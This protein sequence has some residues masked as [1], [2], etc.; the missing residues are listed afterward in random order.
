MPILTYAN[1]QKPGTEKGK[2]TLPWAPSDF[3]HRQIEHSHK[4]LPRESVADTVA[5]K[6]EI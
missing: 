2:K 1:E 6:E 5:E 4:H 3:A